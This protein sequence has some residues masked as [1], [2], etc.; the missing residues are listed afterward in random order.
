MGLTQIPQRRILELMHPLFDDLF[1]ENTLIIEHKILQLI[2]RGSR[3]KME[4]GG[5]RVKMGAPVLDMEP[6]RFRILESSSR[7]IPRRITRPMRVGRAAQG[8]QV[9]LGM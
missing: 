3:S 2:V 6:R 7:W 9:V 8:R 1:A 5:T 4:M